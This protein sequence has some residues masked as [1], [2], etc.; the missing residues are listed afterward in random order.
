M[1]PR[2]SSRALFFGPAALVATGAVSVLTGF[3]PIAGA[4]LL[5]VGVGLLAARGSNIAQSLRTP[6][7]DRN[8]RRRR[9]LIS[10]ACAVLF[11]ASVIG[12]MIAIGDDHIGD[13][14]LL[15]YNAVGVPSMIGTLVFLIAGLL[16]PRSQ[17]ST[18]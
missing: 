7:S 6:A 14:A 18:V 8:V 5:L 12:Y 4:I 9:L 11:G 16:A 10:A 2:S 17:K 1:S 3:V 15:A 13:G